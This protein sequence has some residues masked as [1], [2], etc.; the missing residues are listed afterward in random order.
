MAESCSSVIIGS[1]AKNAKLVVA[2][3]HPNEESANPGIA[4]NTDPGP[5]W[6]T[7]IVYSI[8]RVLSSVVKHEIKVYD[9]KRS[10]NARK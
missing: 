6:K 7:G 10:L 1:L 5:L 2:V 8:I 4:L 3:L 9:S